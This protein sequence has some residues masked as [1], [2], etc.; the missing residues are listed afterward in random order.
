MKHEDN[1][2]SI[3]YYVKR[4]LL[5]ER[6][7]FEGKDIIDFPAGNGISSEIIREIGGHPMPF[8]LFP[9][10]FRVPGLECKR[11]D[12]NVGIPV[13]NNSVD[14]IVCQE[15][16]EHFS[17]QAKAFMEFGRILRVGGRLI[18]T[19]PNYSGLRSKLSYLLGETER[20]NSLMAPN[21]LDSVWMSKKEISDQ[22][23]YGH[24]F[25]IGILK[26]RC[27]GRL[28]GF[29]IKHIEPTRTK[30]T[31][32][33]LLVLFYPFILLSNWYAYKKNMRK[34]KDFDPAIKKAT[35]LE[36]FKLATSPSILVDGHLFVEFEKEIEQEEVVDRFRSRH[37]EFGTT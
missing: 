6:S 22:V 28:A 15:G 2:K 18:I 19:T 25:L 30:L 37:K 10:Y 5:R 21:E 33:I 24:I 26:M 7:W 27:L 1:P 23:Y 9:E 3:K 29:R 31:S 11:A 4:Y 17:D 32:V 13:E 34:N 16:I 8:D 20:F 35:Y 12:I 14:A 36:I